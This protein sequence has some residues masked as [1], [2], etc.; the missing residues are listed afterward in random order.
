MANI[1]DV[2]RHAG[3]STAT[4]SRFLAGEHVRSHDAVAAAVEALDYRPS[5]T[6]RGLRMGRHLAVGVVVPDITNP[7]FAAVTRGVEEVITP[8]GLQVVIANS[9][10][11]VAR[12]AELVGDLERR[13][14]GIVLAPAT[15]TDVVPSRLA[16][17]GTPVVFVDRVVTSGSDVDSVEVDNAAGAR[18]AAEHL[19]GL[20]HRAIAVISGPQTCTP[21]RERHEVF[22]AV[23]AEHGVVPAA[24]HVEIADFTEAGGSAAMHRLLERPDRPTAVFVANNLMVVGALKAIRLRGLRLPDALSVVGFD[25]L[26]LGALLDPPLTVV[27]RPTVAQGAAA[28]RLMLARLEHPDQPRASLTLPVELVVRGSTAA[29]PRSPHA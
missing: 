20:G 1:Q 11:S 7:F 3:V 17:S 23:L 18:L 26:D 4:V 16:A 15:E 10:E 9:G 8:A 27:D 28:G 2:A 6:A 14:D 22:L 13:V 24:D 21:G 19:L 29:P 5:R 25:D 12:E